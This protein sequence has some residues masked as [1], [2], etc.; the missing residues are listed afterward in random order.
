VSLE[1]KKSAQVKKSVFR[2]KKAVKTMLQKKEGA[3]YR[4]KDGAWGEGVREYERFRSGRGT[5]SPST[6]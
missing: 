4:R 5:P 6:Q 2:K 1:P 3:A